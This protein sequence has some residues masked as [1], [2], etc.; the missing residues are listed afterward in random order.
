MAI[1]VENR[2]RASQEEREIAAKFLFS[3]SGIS[4]R[5]ELFTSWYGRGEGEGEVSRARQN[6]KDRK[7][8]QGE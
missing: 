3:A 1:V 8:K 2:E 5:A 6:R 4:S 7:C